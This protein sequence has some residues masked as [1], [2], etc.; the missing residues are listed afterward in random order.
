[1]KLRHILLAFTI[2]SLAMANHAAFAS[3]V[4]PERSVRLVVPF[5]PGGGTDIVARVVGV[6]LSEGLKQSVVIDNRPGGST[7]IGADAVAKAAPD[8]YTLLLS[9]SSTYTVNPATRSKLPYDTFK[10]LVPIAIVARTPLVLL[11]ANNSPW[12]TL[13][14]LVAAA[15]ARPGS[16]NYAT[17]GNGS[18]P[19]LAGE[20]LS[21]AA[22]IKLQ[23]VPF[24]GGPQAALAVLSGDLH[25]SIDTVAGAV[26][27]VKA[28]K[29]K[30]LAVF[31]PS[32]A[33]LLPDVRTM[34]EHQ[35][36]AATF[37]GW[38]GLA[39]PAHTPVKVIER[40][41]RVTQAA[42][43]DAETQHRL[44]GQG[45]EP[46]FIEANAMRAQMESEITRYRALA[47]KAGMVVE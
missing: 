24:K 23:D 26:A 11:V 19:H 32:R 31:G 39:A 36:P 47:Q 5:P 17:F 42:M 30:A 4:W 33:S 13:D 37:D 43:R 2:S 40:L 3:D 25:I 20:L 10:D 18:A 38:Y 44:L 34:T 1:M 14:D 9:G 41:H 27:Q 8:G 12:S 28:G 21:A 16:I 7:I 29:M 35:L 6:K 46:V 15:K 45:M 22:G